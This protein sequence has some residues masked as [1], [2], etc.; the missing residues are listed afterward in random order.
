MVTAVPTTMYAT[1]NG[2]LYQTIEGAQTAEVA[3]GLQVLLANSSVTNT[4][5]GL[6][7]FLVTNWPQ[8]KQIV[9]AAKNDL[10]P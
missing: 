1:A 7:A 3:D 6:A 5:A 8:V 10:T 2:V 9:K 4:I